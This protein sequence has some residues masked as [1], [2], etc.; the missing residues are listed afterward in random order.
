M[1][2]ERLVRQVLLAKPTESDPEVVQSLGGVTASPNLLGPVLVWSQQN[3]LKLLL[4]V[5][6]S[7]L[8]YGCCSATL[9]RWKAGMKMKKMNDIYVQ[10]IHRCLKVYSWRVNKFY[11]RQELINTNVETAR[12]DFYISHDAFRRK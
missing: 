12:N 2:H 3:Y 9:P 6:Y 5:R 11:K 8:S 1:P 10:F 4:T 7:K